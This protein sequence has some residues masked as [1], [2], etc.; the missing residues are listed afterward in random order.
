M[1][2][3][4]DVR[5]KILA[6]F[7]ILVIS[8]YPTT[9]HTA[10]Y[11]PGIA[12]DEARAEIEDGINDFMAQIEL[13]ELKGLF[14]KN[15]DVFGGKPFEE[16][17]ADIS[18]NGL[19]EVTAEEALLA[20]GDVFKEALAGSVWY[21]AE[22]VL[23][24]LIAGLLRHVQGSFQSANV[25]RSAFLAGYIVVASIAAVMLTGSIGTVTR[26]LDSLF[27]ITETI[28]PVLMAIL[29]G[30]GGLSAS[31][32]MSPVMAALTGTVFALVKNIVFPAI[33]IAAVLGLV[34]NI[35]STIKL[36][37]FSDLIISAVKWLLGIVFTVFLGV[38]ALKG[39]SGAAIDGI[40]FKTAK[41]TI[42]KMVPVI[43]GMFSD[44][45]DTLMACGLIVK[46]S[47]GTVGLII[48]ACTMAVPLASLV[49]D[50]FLLKAGA[51]IAE[52][53]SDERSGKMLNSIAAITQ[54]LFLVLLTC[55][56]MAFISLSLLMGAADMSLMLR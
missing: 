48:L 34:S 8:F 54:L 41:Y 13:D 6:A 18:E 37:R 28:T 49:I 45:L 9:A 20:V 25:S 23:I 30:M 47:V 50:S 2:R 19:S 43:G 38:S 7:I 35:S 32:V 51:A 21:L 11:E 27:A 16:V 56:A 52:P 31:S 29:T 36:Q 53:F 1:R 22:M 3:G 17:I 10:E 39:M 42:D 55:S 15:R 44:T 14:E 24:L 4:F 40:S 46:N 26:A 5:K 12:E 33:I